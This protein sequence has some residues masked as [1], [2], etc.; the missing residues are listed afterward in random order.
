MSSFAVHVIL[1]SCR[2]VW[3]IVIGVFHNFDV[4]TEIARRPQTTQCPASVPRPLRRCT[5]HGNEQR[6][7][8]IC[9]A[10]CR[11]R[12]GCSGRRANRN[13]A[14]HGRP[15]SQPEGGG[16]GGGATAARGEALAILRLVSEP[17]AKGILAFALLQVYIPCNKCCVCDD[18]RWQLLPAGECPRV[19]SDQLP[20]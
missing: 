13:S 12:P 20:C 8:G 17:R 1:P 2:H 11:R 18:E 7:R 5:R 3:D 14:G 19:H 16:V 6:P 9:N 15:S 4:S 10:C